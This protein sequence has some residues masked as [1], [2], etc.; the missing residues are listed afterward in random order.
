ME[1]MDDQEFIV[2]QMMEDNK[3]LVQR[4]ADLEKL[5]KDHAQRE[6]QLQ[7]M[8]KERENLLRE[9]Y[10]QTNNSMA[11]IC[12]LLFMQSNRAEN[13]HLRQTLKGIENRIRTMALIQEKFYRSKDL[14]SLDLHTFVQ[15]V[16]FLVYR[17]YQVDAPLVG[18]K[19]DLTAQPPVSART[20]IPCGLILHE[21]ISNAMK[22]A[23]PDNRRG[24]IMVSLGLVDTGEVI[25]GVA[26]NGI[27]L[28][29]DFD[30]ERVNTMGLH[31]VQLLGERQLG[32]KVSLELKNGTAWFIHFAPSR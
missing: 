3:R 32:G 8:I 19:F 6:D 14:V 1:P 16:S 7:L 20:I 4:V 21:L 5:E 25:L 26:D 22:F 13:A 28:P 29:E 18:L 12:N 30:L 2:T 31:L 27:G 11:T 15:E 17:S 24:E 9:V 23:F 10:H